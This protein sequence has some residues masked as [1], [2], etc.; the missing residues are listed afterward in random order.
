MFRRFKLI[1]RLL[2]CV[3]LWLVA[4]SW[5]SAAEENA[6]FTE[7]QIKAGYL[8]NFTQFTDWP[9]NAFST[10]NAPIVIGILGDDPFGKTLDEL[11]KNEIVRGHPLVIKRLNLGD[12]LQSC[13]LLFI[14]RNEKEQTSA[15]LQ[16]LKGRPV[17]TVGDDEDFAKSGGMVNFVLVQKKV[18][19]E[20]NPAAA[21]KAGLQISAKLLKLAR[22]VN[23][24]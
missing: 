15:L 20:I 23:P 7:Y 5:L 3:C 24:N 16:K 14:C 12:D 17:L 11:V 13:Q 22:I 18:K 8:Y 1:K 21:E 9:T 19:L 10:A 6:N 4:C 2:S